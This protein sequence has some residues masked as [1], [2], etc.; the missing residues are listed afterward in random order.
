MWSNYQF[1]IK[2]W[3]ENPE[4]LFLIGNHETLKVARLK[5][6][7]IQ[8]SGPRS[9]SDAVE[10]RIRIL[11]NRIQAFFKPGSEFLHVQQ[12]QLHTDTGATTKLEAFKIF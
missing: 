4:K 12:V 6:N 9:G 8:S 3:K 5:K 11:K 7:N 1:N 2:I 10:D